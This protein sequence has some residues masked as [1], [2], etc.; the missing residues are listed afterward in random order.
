MASAPACVWIVLLAT[1]LN[2]VLARHL[3]PRSLTPEIEK[4]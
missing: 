2:V 4:D 3:R 1:E